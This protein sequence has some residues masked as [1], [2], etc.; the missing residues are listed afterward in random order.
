MKN[1]IY[2]LSV[3][4]FFIYILFEITVGREMRFVKNEL[5]KNF[6]S[7]EAE[8]YKSKIKE[9]AKKLLAKDKIFYEEDAE[10]I[11]KLLKKISKELNLN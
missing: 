8:K 3:L 5:I 7:F 11:S 6:Q 4:F 1:Y 10:I 2:K 9:E